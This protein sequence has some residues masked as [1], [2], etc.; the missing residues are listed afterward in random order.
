MQINTDEQD[1]LLI[2]GPIGKLDTV[3]GP[4]FGKTLAQLL[5][6]KPW[7]CLIDLGEVSYIS[8]SGLQ[9]LLVGAKLARNE[10]ISFG[11]FGMNPMVH[12]IFTISGFDRFIESFVDRDA[13]L[14]GVDGAG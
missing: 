4:E 1:G 7:R 9:V 12:E 10:R 6:Q 11:V 13:A 5:A 2:V 3:N 14:A 8:S